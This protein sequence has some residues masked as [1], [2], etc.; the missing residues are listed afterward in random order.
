MRVSLKIDGASPEQARKVASAYAHAFEAMGGRS[1]NLSASG[2]GD[3]PYVLMHCDGPE[4]WA[5][6]TPAIPADVAESML[7][8][9]ANIG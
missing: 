9:V 5:I 2:H 4:C 3:R 1:T 7:N 8:R 6:V